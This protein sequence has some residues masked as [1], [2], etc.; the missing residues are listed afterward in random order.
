MSLVKTTESFESDNLFAG[1]V[2]PVN[3]EPGTVASGQGV[4]VRGTVLGKLTASGKLAIV[5]S[6][7]ADGSQTIYA[8]L[9]EDVDATSADVDCPIYLTGEFNKNELV[10]GGSD[11][12]DTH[13][14][15]AREIGIFFKDVVS[16]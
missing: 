4:L 9:A 6:A 15:K 12:A 3:S 1:W 10:F 14:T 11:T 13:A 7:Q 2:Q 8:V 5:D 16:K